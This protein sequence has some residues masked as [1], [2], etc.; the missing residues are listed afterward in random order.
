MERRPGSFRLDIGRP[1]DLGPFLRF[2]GDE[3]SEFSAGRFEHQVAKLNNAGADLWIIKTSIDPIMK[4][5]ND[6]TGSISW[7]SE[8]F[9]ASRLKSGNCFT[10]AL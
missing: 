3:L 2:G 6:F 10:K 9:P 7:S 4:L 8:A 1:H 5:I